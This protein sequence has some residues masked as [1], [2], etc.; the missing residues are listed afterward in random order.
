MTAG[1]LKLAESILRDGEPFFVLNS[2]VICGFPFKELVAFHR[3]HGKE[4]TILVRI[5]L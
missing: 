2:D 5:F 3:Q 1:P 4:G